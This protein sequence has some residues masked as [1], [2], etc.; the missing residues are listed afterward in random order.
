MKEK[1]ASNILWTLMTFRPRISYCL[2]SHWTL[3]IPLLALSLSVSPSLHLSFSPSLRLSVPPSLRLSVSPSL[4]PS[5]PPSLR[6]SVS[7][8]LRLSLPLYL[9]LFLFLFL[10]TFFFLIHTHTLVL[11]LSG[12]VGELARIELCRHERY[13]TPGTA[14][15]IASQP[16]YVGNA[17]ASLWASEPNKRIYPIYTHIYIHI[18]L[19]HVWGLNCT[20]SVESRARDT[21]SFISTSS[22]YLYLW[23]F[24]S[25][26]RS[27]ALV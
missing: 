16:S 22:L 26:V 14:L 19:V 9:S 7:P 5:V 11:A 27:L 15:E 3:P 17:V 1:N 4:R 6:L 2:R 12:F 25:V 24:V 21:V 13:A 10:S 23:F 20:S 8:S 18:Y